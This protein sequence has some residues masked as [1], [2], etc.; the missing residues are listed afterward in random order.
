MSKI[1]TI[2]ATYS[3]RMRIRLESNIEVEARIKGKKIKAV[4]GDVV[5]AEP[6]KDEKDWLIT[7]IMERRNALTRPN[8]S[9]QTEVLAANLDAVIIVTSVSPIPDWYIVD[10][11]ICAAEILGIQPIIVFNKT[12]L[13]DENIKIDE[14]LEYK[15]LGFSV[16]NFSVKSKKGSKKLLSLISEKCNIVV[17]QSGVGKS[18]IINKL[19]YSSEQRVG[20]ISKSGEGRHTTVNSV[21]KSL[22]SGGYLIDSP[23]VRDYMPALATP[24]EAQRGFREISE[25][26]QFCRFS[27]C[28]HLREPKCAVKKAVEENLIDYRRYE[29]YKRVVNL[30]SKLSQKK[31]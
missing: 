18:S 25:F 7:E 1:A 16:V 30:T 12:D 2:I 3:R 5:T 11:Y 9:G 15:R 21:M 24:A 13:L 10:R 6:I 17:G 29:S 26:S 4:C 23:G 19:L 14:L 27:N 31:Y 22:K 8:K 28:L 20:G